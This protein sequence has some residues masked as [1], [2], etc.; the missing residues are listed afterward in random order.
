MDC[1]KCG[2]AYMVSTTRKDIRLRGVPAE[3]KRRRC[4]ECNYRG[5]YYEIPEALLEQLQ[6]DALEGGV[7]GEAGKF[8]AYLAG[9]RASV[10]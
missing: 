3:R 2:A 10:E 8:L 7:K 6:K 4:V 9:V 1:P 5:T